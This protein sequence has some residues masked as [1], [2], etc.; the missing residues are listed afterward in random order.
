[1]DR[2]REHAGDL[3]VVRR[4]SLERRMLANIADAERLTIDALV[5][6]VNNA[7][8]NCAG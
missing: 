7:L 2:D 3:G 5:V 4:K 6:A 8:N 1:V